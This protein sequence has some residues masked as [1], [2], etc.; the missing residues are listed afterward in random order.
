MQTEV[1]DKIM[2]GLNE[3]ITACQE[4]LGS[5]HTTDDIA[6]LSIKDAVALRDF[7]MNEQ[8]KMTKA[9]M[10]ELYHIIGMGNLTA[11]QMTKF[12]QAIKTYLAFRSIIKAIA[13]NLTDLNDL[14]AI[15]V[16]TKYKLSV[17]A[18]VTLHAGPES[19]PVVDDTAGIEDATPPLKA[20]EIPYALNGKEITIPEERLLEFFRLGPKF[21]AATGNFDALKTK[22]GNA[23][24][25][26]GIKWVGIIDK[27]VY[28]RVAS[29]KIYCKLKEMS[30]IV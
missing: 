2:T 7:C 23:G 13:S 20:S 14:P 17:L 25:Y 8:A 22:I 26:W 3:R 29:S 6:E 28:G 21:G 10:V 5:I 16:H 12:I 27:V 4:N 11:V 15:P 9:V 24:E 30:L 1:F 19:A 18:D